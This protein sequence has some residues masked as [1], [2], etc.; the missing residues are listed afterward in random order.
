M[1]KKVVVV[2]YVRKPRD[3]KEMAK[4]NKKAAQVRWY[5]KKRSSDDLSPYQLKNQE[6][7]DDDLLNNPDYDRFM[8]KIMKKGKGL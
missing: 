3:K 7:W 5:K 8:G 2:S 1:D 4:N 6:K